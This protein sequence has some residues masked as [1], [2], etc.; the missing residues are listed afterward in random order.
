MFRALLI[1]P[2]L[3]RKADNLHP[4]LNLVYLA[5][6]AQSCPG[7]GC[8]ILDLSLECL[9]STS[10]EGDPKTIASKVVHQKG[11]FNVVGIAS[12]CDSFAEALAIAEEVKQT[13]GCWIV[14]GGPHATFLGKEILGAYPFVD[15]VLRFDATYSFGQLCS[16]LQANGIA[17]THLKGIPSL[18]YRAGLEIRETPIQTTTQ[19]ILEV[20]PD[21]D[22]LEIP[23]YLRLNP[24]L[25]F[26]VLAGTGC[27][28]NCTFCSTSRMWQRKYSARRVSHILRDI[29]YLKNKYGIHS[30]GLVH[31][32]LLFN[33]HFSLELAEKLKTLHVS[34]SCS[35]RLDHL[36]G[37]NDVLEALSSAGCTSVFIGVET[38]SKRLQIKTKKKL[39]PVQAVEVAKEMLK[40]QLAPVFSF[41]VG[42][43]SETASEF[44]RTI[45]LASKL[46]VLGAERVILGS[47][48]PLPGTQIADEEPLAVFSDING[49]E[50]ELVTTAE[51]I[52]ALLVSPKLRAT[53]SFVTNSF[54]GRNAKS[55]H[56]I[57]TNIHHLI[58]RYPST[59]YYLF[60]TA[61]VKPSDCLDW[62]SSPK[63]VDNLTELL[64]KLKL[65]S[66]HRALLLQLIS[67]E[68]KILEL[69]G[70]PN[71]PSP[72]SFNTKRKI[73]RRAFRSA[74]ISLSDNLVALRSD[75]DLKSCLKPPVQQKKVRW[76]SESH[77][78][79]LL[80]DGDV[81]VLAIS[82]TFYLALDFICKA[83]TAQPAHLQKKFALKATRPKLLRDLYSLYELGGLKVNHE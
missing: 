30:F 28:Y 5:T 14:F 25:E 79:L 27:P 44:D 34:W 12:L 10:R 61:R 52:Q 20:D 82:K 19:A 43:P 6:G 66:E 29:E 77:V 78:G 73:S 1:N 83:G 80:V 72:H 41:I 39:N 24:H 49:M 56:V 4:P 51:S 15:F 45:R 18:C 46:K 36:R 26:P 59:L 75:F 8:E 35:S 60:H 74:F 2:V 42:L 16:T 68:K 65:A 31:D 48:V 63:L 47:L 57:A 23:R 32:N 58:A 55:P 64:H 70:R 17:S 38:A 62:L 71:S 53:I 69:L 81:S 3:T 13:H 22:S 33:Q 54:L 76:Q 50:L 7:G 37:K 21:Y 9:D 11:P 67:C 40:L